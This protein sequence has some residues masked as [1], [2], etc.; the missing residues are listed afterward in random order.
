MSDSINILLVSKAFES[1]VLFSREENISIT[2]FVFICGW[3]VFFTLWRVFELWALEIQEK[4]VYPISAY[5]KIS[6]FSH[7]LCTFY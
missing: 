5:S 7:L 3:F 1:N 4:C 2:V 6:L